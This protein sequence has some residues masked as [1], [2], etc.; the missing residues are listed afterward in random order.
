MINV[1][2]K[3]KGTCYANNKH[4]DVSILLHL[5]YLL[6]HICTQA[7]KSLGTIFRGLQ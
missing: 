7:V 2:N 6:Y 1:D 5:T 4:P 3:E